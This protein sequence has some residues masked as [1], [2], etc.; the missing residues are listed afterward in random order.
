MYVCMYVCMYA[1]GSESADD[2]V[3]V[4]FLFVDDF[5]T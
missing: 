2:V 5:A 1:Y 3:R 4:P